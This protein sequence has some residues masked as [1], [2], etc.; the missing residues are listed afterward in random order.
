M[1]PF[2]AVA[3]KQT[4]RHELRQKCLLG[5]KSDVPAATWQHQS[6]KAH[7]MHFHF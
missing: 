2:Q 7:V 3:T 1:W 6:G 5:G 4:T